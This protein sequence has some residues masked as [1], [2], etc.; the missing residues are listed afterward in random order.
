MAGYFDKNKDY[1]AA[2]EAAKKSGASQSEINR[3]QQERQNK[4]DAVYGGNEPNM[5]NSNQTYSQATSG[6]GSSSSVNNA[7]SIANSVQAKKDAA[8]QKAREAAAAGNWDAAASYTNEIA[9]ATPKNPQDGYDMSEANAFFKQLAKEYGYDAN[10]YYQ[11]KYDSVYGAGA[12]DGGTGTGQPVFNDYSKALVDAYNKKNGIQ[13]S[14]P[15]MTEVMKGEVVNPYGQYGSFD[16]FLSGMGYDSYADATQQAIRAAVQQAIGGYNQQIEDT[17]ED[18][19]ELARQAYVNMMMGGKNLDQQLA[20]NGYAGGMADSQRI[21]L[22]ANYENDLNNL[23]RQ[24]VA[25]INELQRAITNAQLTGDMQTAQE[26]ANYLQQIQGQWNN[27]VI[28]QQQMANDN[29]WRQQS[30]DADNQ[31]RAR[32]MALMIM[33]SGNMPDD[34]TL[35]AAGIS[36]TQAQ[37]LLGTTGQTI[38]ATTTRRTGGG[39]NNGGLTRQQVAEMQNYLGVTAD[40]LWGAQ[41]QGQTG[42]TADEAWAAYQQALAEQQNPVTE[43]YATKTS[44]R[45][46][47]TNYSEVLNQVRNMKN[48]GA[49]ETA[50]ENYLDQFSN[51]QL[52]DAGLDRILTLLNIGGYRT[53]SGIGGL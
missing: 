42:M 33:Q 34:E 24:R 1:S 27:Y 38:P 30:I 45:G 10:K 37:A 51:A 11:Q 44:A 48:S 43:E 49:N 20:A 52:T 12:W 18:S 19:K 16:E 28:N 23:E 40:G 15:G 2:I 41:S 8:M 17:N 32:E 9:F 47:G 6:G 7:V 21:A 3:L 46:F 36:R 4:I 53:F 35:N 25:T 22:Q 39:Y 29:Y 26:L 14:V 13:T 5:Y 50:I 31:N